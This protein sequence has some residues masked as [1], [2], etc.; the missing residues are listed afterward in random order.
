MAAPANTAC[1][2]GNASEDEDSRLADL[3]KAGWQRALR[4]RMPAIAP[5]AS[6]N[7]LRIQGTL[8]GSVEFHIGRRQT[9][10]FFE[11]GRPGELKLNGVAWSPEP[12]DKL[13]NA[14]TTAHLPARVYMNDVSVEAAAGRGIVAFRQVG[15]GPDAQCLV[16]IEDLPDGRD[17][18]DIVVRFG[19][20]LPAP[21]LDP[22]TH[23]R[24]AQ[25]FARHPR[26]PLA[27][28]P[29]ATSQA[30]A[31][32]PGRYLYLYDTYGS[33]NAAWDD[34]ARAFLTAAAD[35][36]AVQ[37]QPRMVTQPSII[38]YPK[39]MDELPDVLGVGAQ[40]AEAGCDD[41]LVLQLYGRNLAVSRDFQAA[42]R[43]LDR[44]VEGFHRVPYPKWCSCLLAADQAFVRAGLQGGDPTPDAELMTRAVTE[45]AA[46]AEGPFA[47]SE[48]RHFWLELMRATQWPAFRGYGGAVLAAISNS[49]RVDP[50]LVHLLNWRYQFEIAFDDLPDS[51][52]LLPLPLPEPQ[53]EA[54]FQ[55][56]LAVARNHLLEAWRLHPERPEA[57]E[58][59]MVVA[60]NRG[61]IAGET[62]RFWFDRAVEG[63]LG[64]QRAYTMLLRFMKRSR[65]GDADQMLAFARECLAVPRYD[66]DVPWIAVTTLEDDEVS[67]EERVNLCRRPDVS[68]EFM[69][70]LG[71]YV[72]HSADANRVRD[73]RLRQLALAAHARQADAVRDLL[74]ELGEK[75]DEGVLARYALTTDLIRSRFSS[76]GQPP[77]K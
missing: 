1:E 61:S 62:R 57:A 54:Q 13:F 51:A 46:A 50:W 12:G 2:C 77:A 22:Q 5:P 27:Q 60:G 36:R 43:C 56:R 9:E 31:A 68:H 63:E 3:A 35:S 33:R 6:Y 28:Q 7:E 52:V 69:A 15:R 32:L 45:I 19:V 47:G 75:L 65:G 11:G 20:L 70:M 21:D 4:G 55:Q 44:A 25:M 74:A 16:R 76:A 71:G 29:G 18:Y 34:A 10:C 24:V 59:L 48:L 23:D 38:N 39:N 73:A 53:Q 14:R 41:P 64:Y 30:P 26:T 49:A 66:T 72:Q 40:A 37:F 17:Q 58:G 8:D 67:I 42:D